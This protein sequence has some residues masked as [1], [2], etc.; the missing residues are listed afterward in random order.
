VDLSR[1]ALRAACRRMPG[2]TWLAVNADRR[3]PF[4]DASLDVVLSL[5]G[6]RNGPEFR[7]ILRPEGRLCVAVPG[8]DDLVELRAV[9]LGAERPLEPA[10]RWIEALARDFDLDVR[11][12]V[13]RSVTLDRDGIRD[14]LAMSYRGQR[15]RERARAAVLD[16]LEVTA[17]TE[18]LRFRPRR[19]AARRR[20]A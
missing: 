1:D 6:R 12:V 5:Y 20:Q 3:L 14:A 15:H 13:R 16:G 2:A 17:S 11:R 8:A 10:S 7:R 18:L 9:V 19:V 4:P